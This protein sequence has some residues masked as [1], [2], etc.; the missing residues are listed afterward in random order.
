MTEF[1]INNK[2][3]GKRL[4]TYLKA[5]F[6][7]LPHTFI[8]K[9]IRQKKVKINNTKPKFDQKLKEQ[10]RVQIY[11]RDQDLHNRQEKKERVKQITKINFQIIHED[12]QILVINK[13]AGVA[14][15]AGDE[16]KNEITLMDQVLKYLNYNE[17]VFKPYLA[18]R[19]DRDTSGILIIGK[20]KP[21]LEYFF[22]TF[23]NNQ[24]Q[25]TYLALVLGKMKK[26]TDLIDLPILKKDRGIQKSQIDLEYGKTAQT[27]YK[28]LDCQEIKFDQ[29]TYDVS[30][31]ELK[32]HTGRTHQIRVHLQAINHPII[33]D[34]QYGEWEIN[35]IFKNKFS[36]KRQFL[37]AYS[38]IFNH[39]LSAEKISLKAELSEDLSAI[40]SKLQI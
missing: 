7:N 10:D 12:D 21:A 26:K 14:V 18:H 11:I 5:V 38:L 1:E 3:A 15:H 32:L 22:K 25:K 31:L 8:F 35:K 20:T 37:H 4:D 29:Q 39:P 2:Q 34:R 23:K 24:V 16:G 17:T 19:L 30:L 13:P 9:I 40:L 6:P 27:E 28:V 36:L 33:G